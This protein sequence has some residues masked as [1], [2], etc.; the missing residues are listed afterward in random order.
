MGAFQDKR[1]RPSWRG[2]YPTGCSLADRNN[3]PALQVIMAP[4]AR[5]S[6][7]LSFPYPSAVLCRRRSWWD[8]STSVAWRCHLHVRSMAQLHGRHRHPSSRHRPRRHGDHAA[9]H[10]RER[11]PRWHLCSCLPLLTRPAT[12]PQLLHQKVYDIFGYVSPTWN[13]DPGVAAYI[14][15]V[16]ALAA[17]PA[18]LLLAR[19]LPASHRQGA[20]IVV[21]AVAVLFAL[22]VCEPELFPYFMSPAP[23]HQCGPSAAQLGLMAGL[24]HPGRPGRS[25]DEPATEERQGV[26]KQSDRV[27][28]R[29]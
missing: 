13:F 14:R 10:P 12:L 28:V 5:L 29:P 3:A 7:G 27:L 21:W 25:R 8:R 19:Y 26:R 9:A 18:A 1:G 24:A 16:V 17:L 4:I 11:T 23:P 2:S 22:R 20:E 6:F 15:L